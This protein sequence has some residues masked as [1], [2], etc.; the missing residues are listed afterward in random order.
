MSKIGFIGLG[1]MGTPMAE[2]LIEAGHEVYLYSIPSIPDALVAAGGKACGILTPVE[3]E[4]RRYIEWGAD[5]IA[6]G[7]DLGLFRSATQA[8]RDKF[9]T[10]G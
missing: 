10:A 2:H 3:A 1:I 9:A 8:L 5:F 4:A 6:V 7:S